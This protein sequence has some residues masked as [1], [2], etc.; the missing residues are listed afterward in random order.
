MP[1]NCRH[2]GALCKTECMNCGTPQVEHDKFQSLY[3]AIQACTFDFDRVRVAKDFVTLN[4]QPCLTAGHVRSIA[5]MCTFD[6]GRVGIFHA[7][8]PIITNPNGILE[9]IDVFSFDSSKQE[10]LHIITR[11]HGNDV[12]TT[13][14]CGCSLLILII[15]VVL[16][17]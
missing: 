9:A 7:L 17:F 13:A 4:P 5:E 3:K 6:S 10:V 8:Y 16:I 14:G 15:L 1:I 11:P 2:C 12:P